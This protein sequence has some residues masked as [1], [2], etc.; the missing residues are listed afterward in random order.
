MK[1]LW[2][3]PHSLLAKPKGQRGRPTLQRKKESLENPQRTLE[4]FWKEETSTL[5]GRFQVLDKEKPTIL[6]DN[7]SN[8]DALKNLLLGIR[9]MHYKKPLKGLAFIFAC[10][11]TQINIEEFLR[12]LRYF[13]KK[14]SGQIIFCPLEGNVPGVQEESWDVEQIINDVKSLKVKAKSAKNFEEAYEMAKKSL[15]MNVMD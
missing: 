3:L 7:A 2:F 15:M 1:A 12:L 4:Q 14:N 9:L 11:K 5:P 10:D 8:V 6:L 13:S